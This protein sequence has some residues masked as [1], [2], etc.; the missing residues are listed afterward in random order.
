VHQIQLTFLFTSP[1]YFHEFL[2]VKLLGSWER[3]GKGLVEEGL[4]EVLIPLKQV[5]GRQR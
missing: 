4:E 5:K 2:L 1:L 3:G